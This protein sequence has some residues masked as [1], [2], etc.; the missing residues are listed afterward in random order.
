M[1]DAVEVNWIILILLYDILSSRL[2]TG[3]KVIL[4]LPFV[5]NPV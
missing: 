1:D 5:S 2:K 3:D 4:I